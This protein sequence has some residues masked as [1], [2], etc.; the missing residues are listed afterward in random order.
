MSMEIG[1]V[2]HWMHKKIKTTE[3]REACIANAFKE[4]YGG[5]AEDILNK[6]YEKHPQSDDSKSLE[7][8]LEGKAIHPT[9]QAMI[10]VAETRE[11]AT[12][13]AFCEKHGEEAKELAIKSARDHGVEC[14]KTAA[15]EE[16]E[17]SCTA[18][19]AFELTQNYFCDGMPCDRGGKARG[20]ETDALTTWDHT[21]CIHESYWKE[22]GASF[23][24]MCELVTTWVAGF[25]EGLNPEIKYKREK[26]IA[27]GDSECVSSYEIS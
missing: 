16:G 21:E 9:I 23:E 15:A 25:G 20:E 12:I 18:S 13:A 8:L 19:R 4:K 3:A 5:D 17:S 24:T 22:A 2:H 14:G 6:V 7:E 26:A 11:A 27:F 10:V 1:P